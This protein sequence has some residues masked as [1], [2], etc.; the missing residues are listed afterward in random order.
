MCMQ[1]ASRE[2]Q[3]QT[4][5]F[6]WDLSAL[7]EINVRHLQFR[8]GWRSVETA[9][10]KGR[11]QSVDEDTVHQVETVILEVICSQEEHHV[12]ERGEPKSIRERHGQIQCDEGKMEASGGNSAVVPLETGLS[13]FALM[14]I[15][16]AA[17]LPQ[18]VSVGP[19]APAQETAPKAS[20]G[21]PLP[22]ARPQNHFYPGADTLNNPH[23][24]YP[25]SFRLTNGIGNALQATEF[26]LG[27]VPL[28][29]NQHPMGS[30]ASLGSAA[31]APFAPA[32]H[33]FAQSAPASHGHLAKAP[34][35]PVPLAAAAPTPL[36]PAAPAPLAPAAPA[37]LAPAAPAPLAPAAPAPL[38]PASL[39]LY[40]PT[41]QPSLAPTAA[42]PISVPKANA[43]TKNAPPSSTAPMMVLNLQEFTNKPGATSGTSPD[44]P[45]IVIVPKNFAL[46]N[47][48]PKATSP[49]IRPQRSVP[50]SSAYHT[51]AGY[52]SVLQQILAAISQ[53]VPHNS[54][55]R[56]VYAAAS[57]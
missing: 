31:Q 8:R 43:L 3:H 30:S 32:G 25:L 33:M 45:F 14:L 22:L 38:A 37:P 1:A 53:A 28:P 9:P 24:P 18:E 46:Q 56:Y 55:R 40:T 54:Q 21:S 42:S 57:Q 11:R 29:M 41:L 48:A 26:H 50:H 20:P 23:M 27:G 13:I 4:W 47:P 17:G 5:V 35:A 34:A 10:I 16:T 44:L 6:A 12:Q 15:A 19:S 7:W 2:R 51:D 36:A 39:D 52:A 49:A